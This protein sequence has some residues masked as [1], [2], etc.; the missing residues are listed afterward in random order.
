M[1]D[2]IKEIQSVFDKVFIQT[3]YLTAQQ[4]ALESMVLVVY[5][6]TL[7]IE[8]YRNIYSNY[9]DKLADNLKNALENEDL[10]HILFDS[11]ALPHEQFE[12]F[13]YIEHLKRDPDYLKTDR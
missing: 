1:D 6:E 13:S 9:V 5:K 12:A 3:A 8:T 4:N 2:K 11:H 10:T 7:P